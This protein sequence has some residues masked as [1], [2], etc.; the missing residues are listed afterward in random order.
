MELLYEPENEIEAQALIGMLESEGIEVVAQRRADTA[1]PGI[2]D[3]AGWGRLLVGGA[4]LAKAQGLVADYLEAE[5][6]P[7]E[8][9][10]EVVPADSPDGPYRSSARAN[11][12]RMG[13]KRVLRNAAGVGGVL[14]FAGSVGLN[15]HLLVEDRD[16]RR[17]RD[18]TVISHDRLGRL[19]SRST[20][21]EDGYLVTHQAYDPRGELQSRFVDSDADARGG[22]T[23]VFHRDGLEIEY[24]DDDGDGFSEY[25]EARRGGGVLHRSWDQNGDGLFE[26]SETSRGAFFSDRDADG[27]QEE[28][29]CGDLVFDADAC[30]VR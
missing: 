10:A 8:E 28:I 4:D 21:S 3:A 13:P 23:V 19:E 27:S 9:F 11:D 2:S 15:A 7:E 14:L 1:Y 16:S 12:Q 5:G 24:I 22:R 29:R 20:Y 17:A 18:S 25:S 30:T 6:E 26:R